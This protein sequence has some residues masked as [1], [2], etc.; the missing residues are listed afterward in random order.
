MAEATPGGQPTTAAD[1][2]GPV[3][4]QYD[5]I[6][7]RIRLNSWGDRLAATPTV[8]SVGASAAI[9]IVVIVRVV[10]PVITGPPSAGLP[11]QLTL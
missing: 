11:G 3:R 8:H 1:S 6:T 9:V 7:G 5:T 2:N 4:R 10:V